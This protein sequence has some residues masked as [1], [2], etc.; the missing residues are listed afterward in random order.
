MPHEFQ[1]CLPHPLVARKDKA[2]HKF[3]A[4]RMPWESFASEVNLDNDIDDF[5]T[6]V[7]IFWSQAIVPRKEYIYLECWWPHVDIKVL[8]GGWFQEYNVLLNNE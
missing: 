4:K 7:D 6:L 1:L 8:K 5:L 3:L 2:Y